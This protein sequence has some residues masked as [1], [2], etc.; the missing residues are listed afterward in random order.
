M[1]AALAQSVERRLGKAEVGGSIPLDSFLNFFRLPKGS[2]FCS[3]FRTTK[4]IN[5]LLPFS[6]RPQ[7]TNFP[8]DRMHHVTDLLNLK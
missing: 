1:H 8:T 3:Y 6:S 7:A 5:T 4:R 2:I